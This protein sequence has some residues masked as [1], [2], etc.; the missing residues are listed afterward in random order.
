MDKKETARKS[1]GTIEKF[2][3]CAHPSDCVRLTL[4][5]NSVKDIETASITW[6]EEKNKKHPELA[7][8]FYEDGTYCHEI[9]ASGN[10]V[11]RKKRKLGL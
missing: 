7:L 9:M 2:E 8:V 1:F 11:Y 6:V 5:D 4:G 3:M 10:Y